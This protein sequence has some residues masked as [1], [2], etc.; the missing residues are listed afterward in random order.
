M[1]GCGHRVNLSGRATAI[2]GLLAA[3]ALG[4]ACS[5]TSPTALTSVNISGTA[6]LSTVG[7][8]TQLTATAL[9]NDSHTQDVTSNANWQSS[10]TA[11]ATVASNGVVTAVASGMSTITAAYEGKLG[12]MN[13]TI[14]ANVPAAG[15][16]TVTGSSTLAIGQTSQ[17]K[18][19]FV[20]NDGKSQD[21][22]SAASWLAAPTSVAT[23]SNAGLATGVSTGSA[24]IT[25]N[26]Q[27]KSS[28]LGVS[29][30]N[31]TL[32]ASCQSI[33]NSGSYSL[34]GNI[35]ASSGTCMTITATNV[36]LDCGNRT[37][38]SASS[39]ALQISNAQ[40]VTVK[41]CTIVS[42][43]NGVAALD[44]AKSQ[45]VSVANP[46]VNSSASGAIGVFIDSSTNVTIDSGTIMVTTQQ[47]YALYIQASSGIQFT[48]NQ[49]T[50]NGDG[51]IQMNST[52][53]TVSA[54][55]FGVSG[56]AMIGG[57]VTL[58]GG[59]RNSVTQN[60]MDGA[61]DGNLS[62][63]G[64]QGADDGV[65]VGQEDNDT[66]Q[67]NRVS[68]VFDA[69]IELI[70]LVTNTTISDNRIANAG[71]TG[72]GAYHGTSWIG[73]TTRNNTVSNSPSLAYIFFGDNAT[74]PFNPVTTASF[75]NNTIGGN[76]FS[77][78][79]ALPPS[80]SSRHIDSIVVDFSSVNEN[81][82]AMPVPVSASGNSI[83][84]NSLATIIEAAF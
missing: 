36:T 57:P 68:N 16:L 15:S 41:D 25:A 43:A 83:A 72:V 11:V 12:S 4:P 70:A 65:V 69:G 62:T 38:S 14:S 8:T 51:Y 19:T 9:F 42:G 6:Q 61:W 31:T 26:Y 82:G 35:S 60:L 50:S 80:Q 78:P 74:S 7:Q 77:S 48:N 64:Q 1:R 52:G 75:Q 63:W 37:I 66:I 84:N 18:A 32:V 13:L 40:G 53:C 67:G 76:T 5:S 44:I 22:T 34:S 24:T 54:N 81:G 47:F 33:Q 49:V 27:G 17:L 20:G 21:V 71:F 79:S 46:T 56:G 30:S 55:T 29:V 73:N 28:S 45:N 59:S 39:T 3:L 58:I 10:N 2:A 23:V